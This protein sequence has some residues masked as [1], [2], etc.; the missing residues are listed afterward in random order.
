MLQKELTCIICPLGCQITLDIHPDGNIHNLSGNKCREG[1][2]YALA[3][4]TQPMRV[5]TTTLLTEGS[6][7]LVAVRTDKPVPRD[8]LK[9]LMRFTAQIKV[10]PP[11]KTGQEIIHNILET[12]ANLIATSTL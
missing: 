7:R 2:K 5:F 3:E 6:R 9:E 1:Q 12:G 11:V 4:A 8:R 10:N